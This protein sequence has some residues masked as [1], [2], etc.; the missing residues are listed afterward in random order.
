[1]KTLR[2]FFRDLLVTENGGSA[3]EYALLISCIVVAIAGSYT[4]LGSE[5]LKLYLN[6][7]NRLPK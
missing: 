2:R 3:V 7:A 5:V 1:M 6:A 4:L